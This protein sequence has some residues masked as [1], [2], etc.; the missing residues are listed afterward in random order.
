MV[1]V[2]GVSLQTKLKTDVCIARRL[3]LGALLLALKPSERTDGAKEEELETPRMAC[4]TLPFPFF[5]GP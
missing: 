2:A 4:G 3:R 1:V 5:C